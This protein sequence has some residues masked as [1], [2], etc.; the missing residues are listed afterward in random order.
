MRLVMPV[1]YPDED[2]RA[3][4]LQRKNQNEISEFFD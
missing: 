2:A 4:D 1:G 3:P